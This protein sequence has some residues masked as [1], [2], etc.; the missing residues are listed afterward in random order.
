MVAAAGDVVEAVKVA[1][2]KPVAEV[3]AVAKLAG[4]VAVV[5]AALAVAIVVAAPVVSVAAL[6][7]D[8]LLYTSPSP[9]D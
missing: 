7:E 9:R 8:C 4:L 1:A 2:D 5:D 3:V 6:V